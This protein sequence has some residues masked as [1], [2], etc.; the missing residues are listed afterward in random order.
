M[1]AFCAVLQLPHGPIHCYALLA[2][3][4]QCMECLAIKS[5]AE[6]EC[7]STWGSTIGVLG[8]LQMAL[9][10]LT[11]LVSSHAHYA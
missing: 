2:I 6:S 7:L 8:N 5:R 10:N 9:I 11:D 4:H 3:D 1:Q